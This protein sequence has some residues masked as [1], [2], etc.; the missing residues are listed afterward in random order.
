MKCN[1]IRVNVLPI[2]ILRKKK[3]MGMSDGRTEDSLILTYTAFVEPKSSVF[4]VIFVV[5]FGRAMQGLSEY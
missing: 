2:N 5:H 3:E 4:L 1:D